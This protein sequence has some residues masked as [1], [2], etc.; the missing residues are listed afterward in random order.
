MNVSPDDRE[1]RWIL[2]CEG[3]AGLI[4][5][6]LLYPHTEGGW[7][8]F[9]ALILVPDLSLLGYLAGPHIG[10]LSYNFMHSSTLPWL[11]F[12]AGM[13]LTLPAMAAVALIW[14]SHIFF[15]RALG[16]GL[17]YKTGFADTHLGSAALPIWRRT[18]DR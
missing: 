5:S 14:I 2:R 6:L 1:V 3:A 10:A 11:I 7:L 18:T 17:K 12:A 15:D 8:L 4:A 16:F 9:A 13:L